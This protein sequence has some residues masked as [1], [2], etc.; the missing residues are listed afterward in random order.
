[1]HCTC[2]HAESNGPGAHHRRQILG[3]EIENQ[4]YRKSG[5]L[6]IISQL[7]AMVILAF[8]IVYFLQKYASDISNWQNISLLDTLLIGA[9]SF[10]SYSAFAYA[11][12]VVLVALGLKGLGPVGWLKV[13]FASRLANLFVTQGG[14]VLRLLI[15]KKK[16]NFSYT[17]AIGVTMYLVWVNAI[18]A[19][20]AS[21]VALAGLAPVSQVYG[22]SLLNWFVIALLVLLAGPPIAASLA[23]RFR[24]AGT[25]KSPLL[26]PFVDIA[27]FIISTTKDRALLSKITILSCVHFSF[28]VGV[29]YFAFR[30]I[31]E[32]VEL[33]AVCIFTTAF[34]FTRY[35][36]IVPGNLGVS[37]LV[38][39][40]V[41]EQ[42]GA[43]F[44]NGLLVSGIVRIVE[45]VMIA[46]V[47]LIY[48]KFRIIDYLR[49]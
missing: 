14:N 1:M 38:G 11:V 17:N 15:L 6:K 36:N 7:I 32:P 21:C 37:E 47:G 12:Y 20:F 10:V 31:G 34:V 46:V 49:R 2:S 33:G 23:I 40:L 24:Q 39:G 28:F 9:W 30:A 8:T 19:L 42:M 48:G 16:Y 44:G 45:V 18:I 13:Y 4:S 43:G 3:D 41:S 22:L 26:S 5:Y 35:I 27:A 25:L 29:N